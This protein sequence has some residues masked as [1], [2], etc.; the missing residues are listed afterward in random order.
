MTPTQKRSLLEL[1][2]S[3]ERFTRSSNDA[4]KSIDTQ[5]KALSILLKSLIKLLDQQTTK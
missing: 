2:Q 5:N 1:K 3:I 4:A